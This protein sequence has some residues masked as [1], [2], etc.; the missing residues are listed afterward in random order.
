MLGEQLTALDFL[1]GMLARWSRNMPKT[2]ADWPH[3]KRYVE[4]IRA[5]PSYRETHH[6]EDLTGW[7]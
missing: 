7:I 6:R 2:A 5:L 1:T 3:V 4:R